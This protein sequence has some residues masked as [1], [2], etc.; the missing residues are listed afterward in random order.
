MCKPLYE[1]EKA[2][3]FLSL[4]ED[5]TLHEVA[6]LRYVE[7]LTIPEIAEKV[8]YCERQVSRFCKKIKQIAQES[9]VEGE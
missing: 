3:A 1:G 2:K 8:G 5:E 6:K 4:F 7:G 9:E